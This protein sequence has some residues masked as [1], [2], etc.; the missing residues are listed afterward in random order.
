MNPVRTRLEGRA[1]L[2]LAALASTATVA[3]VSALAGSVAGQAVSGVGGQPAGLETAIVARVIDGDT[4]LLGDGRTV[5]L[6]GVDAPETSNPNMVS[7][8]PFGREATEALAAAVAGRAVGLERDVTDADHYGRLLRHVWC[9]DVLVAERLAGQGLAHAGAFPPDT[10]HAERILQAEQRA[11]DAGLGL[12]GLPRP[13]SL[14]AFR[15][16]S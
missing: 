4:L 15:S 11:R 8:Q 3:C 5:R 2:A 9:D 10:R 1:P 16:P 6:L 13:T 12:W 7:A 14:P